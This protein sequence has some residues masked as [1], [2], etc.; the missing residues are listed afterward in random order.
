MEGLTRIYIKDVVQMHGVPILI[1][2]GWDIRIH[3][4]IWQPLQEGFG[5]PAGYE[6]CLPPQT[7]D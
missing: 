3:L 7:D 5:N 4:L 6:H 1:I 2:F